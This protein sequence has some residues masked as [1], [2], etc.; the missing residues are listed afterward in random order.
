MTTTNIPLGSTILCELT[1][2][3]CLVDFVGHHSKIFG[4]SERPKYCPGLIHRN[5][6][7]FEIDYATFVIP[8]FSYF[9]NSHGLTPPESVPKLFLTDDQIAGNHGNWW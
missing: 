2:K 8:K 9:Q 5:R 1:I 6:I 7:L 4:M 3:P